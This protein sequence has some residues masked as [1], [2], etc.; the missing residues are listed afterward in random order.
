MKK[1][2]P[3][4]LAL[5]LLAGCGG[6]EASQPSGEPESPAASSSAS[7]VPE[8]QS[9][10]PEDE[11]AGADEPEEPSD[12][13]EPDASDAPLKEGEGSRDPDNAEVVFYGE[14]KGS[15][16]EE[17]M[18][19]DPSGEGLYNISITVQFGYPQGESPPL[20]DFV[21]KTEAANTFAQGFNFD[22]FVHA[23]RGEEALSPLPEVNGPHITLA[24]VSGALVVF[25]DKPQA[26]AYIEGTKE[27]YNV[28]SGTFE[29]LVE[30]M[31]WFGENE[32]AEPVVEI[33]PA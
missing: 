12:D 13:P 24:F 9:L 27:Y 19:G 32:Q 21:L 25:R 30:Y 7:S 3:I 6:G 1:T 28:E 4:L 23:P 29:A 17:L 18:V 14:G 2:L 33:S 31:G 22:R 16:S 26:I 10:P 11:S 8:P 5:L 15:L 20:G